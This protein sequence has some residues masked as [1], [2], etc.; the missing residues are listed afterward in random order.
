MRSELSKRVYGQHLVQQT[1]VAAVK[2][3]L[4][5]DKPHKALVLSFHGWT[6]GGKNYVT[7]ILIDHLYKKGVDS[8]YVHL[9]IGGL[10][11]AHSEDVFLYQVCAKIIALFYI[12]MANGGRSRPW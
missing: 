9:F 7:S 5:N 11:F 4:E 8:A 6:G 1:V 12:W 2:A 3:H 10:H